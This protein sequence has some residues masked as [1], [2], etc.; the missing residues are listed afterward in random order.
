MKTKLITLFALALVAGAF[1]FSVPAYA[2]ASEPAAV[3]DAETLTVNA[4]WLEGDTLHIEVADKNTGADQA[5]TLNLKDYA[6]VNDE[7]VTVQAIDRAGNKSNTIQFKNPFYTVE[8][9]QL[10][11]DSEESAIPQLSDDD[12]QLSTAFTPDGAGTVL[13]NALN[14]EG[15]EFFTIQAED[16][17]VFY[18]I[19]DRERTQDNVYFLNAVT[20]D[21][22]LPLAKPGDGTSES[23]VPTTTP[24]PTTVTPAPETTP[25]PPPAPA[26]NGGVGT[27]AI[28]FIVIAAFAVGGAG[29][30][31]KILRPK[32]L[33]AAAPEEDY[34]EPDDDYADDTAED[35]DYGDI[36]E[37]KDGDGE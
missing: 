4:V 27:G 13:D 6:G 8:N 14:G 9:G 33:G 23:G 16:G 37:E 26:S 29:Y 20:E 5:L 15:K 35:D 3:T 19:V 18:L 34:D 28:V 25:E 17:T 21:D 30:Y 32:K 31:F 10:T 12:S 24:T 7:F 2:S 36:G 11:V 1:L 22:L